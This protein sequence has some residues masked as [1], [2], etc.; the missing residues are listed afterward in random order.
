VDFTGSW[1]TRFVEVVFYRY[2]ERWDG[3][4]IGPMP[5][6]ENTRSFDFAQDDNT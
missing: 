1:Q 6:F 3:Q 5:E 2:L 4:G